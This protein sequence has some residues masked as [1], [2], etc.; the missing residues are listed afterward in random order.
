[1]IH[2]IGTDIVDIRRI[3]SAID[4]FDRRFPERILERSELEEYSL[5]PETGRARF[6]AKRFSVKEA[7]A[8][9]LGTG[10]RK[11]VILKD[12]RVSHDELGKPLL[13]L[14]GKASEISTINKV[15][16]THVSLSDEKNYVVAYVIMTT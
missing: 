9:A 3:Q 11:G 16:R 5:L 8:K 13:N 12:F 7:A 10:F 14:A 4:R 6:L 15:G 1:M 2:G